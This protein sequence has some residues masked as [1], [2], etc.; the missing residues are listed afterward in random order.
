MKLVNL[1]FTNLLAVIWIILLQQRGG[2]QRQRSRFSANRFYIIL[3]F[4]LL[5]Y[6]MHADHTVFTVCM[7]LIMSGKQHGKHFRVRMICA[8]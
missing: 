2:N 7:D 5:H 1:D 3:L 6:N 4:S 8:I